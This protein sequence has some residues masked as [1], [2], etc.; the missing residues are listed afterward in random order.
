MASAQRMIP[1][2]VLSVFFSLTLLAA[3]V[4]PAAAHAQESS[5]I[6]G[7]HAAYADLLDLFYRP[8]DPRDLLVAGWAA[9]RSD[10]ERRGVGTPGPLPELPADSDMAFDAFV[11]AYSNYVANLPPSLSA[12]T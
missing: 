9:L 6:D 11:D 3:S 5:G 7:I 8:L 1:R 4:A 2:S 12:S 10:A